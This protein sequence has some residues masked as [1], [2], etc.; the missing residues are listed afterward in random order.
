M[1]T[2]S[3]PIEA[4]PTVVSVVVPT[5]REAE[6]LPLLVP[7]ISKALRAASAAFE[8]LI[9]DDN[10]QDGTEQVVAELSQVHPVQVLVRRHERGLAGA[11]L[12]GFQQARGDVLA[13]M[14][15]DL[16]HPPQKLTE[17]A[18]AI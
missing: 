12:H 17:M 9:V 16:S 1:D 4:S 8:I 13:C 15:A 10:S 5:Y 18:A 14:D 7:A 2:Q 3:G 6:N 11:V